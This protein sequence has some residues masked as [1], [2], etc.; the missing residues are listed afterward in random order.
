MLLVGPQGQTLLLM[1]DT[2]QD[3]FPINNVTLTFNDTTPTQLPQ[4]G[5]IV[6]GTFRP[7]NYTQV[8]PDNFPAPAPAPP[9]PY[10]STL[11]V[12]N[13]TNPNGI[14]NLFVVDDVQEDAGS[15]AGGWELNITAE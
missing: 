1:S 13:G 12:F 4:T 5:Q 2:G 3:G 15:I 7:T 9:P 8:V 6:S 11:S 10:G 14:W